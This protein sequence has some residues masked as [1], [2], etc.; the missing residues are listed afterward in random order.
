M[1]LADALL[2]YGELGIEVTENGA[3]TPQATTTGLVIAHPQARYTSVGPIGDDQRADYA[4]QVGHVSSPQ[5]W[6]WLSGM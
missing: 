2:H 3:L 6:I 5:I 1:F 4:A